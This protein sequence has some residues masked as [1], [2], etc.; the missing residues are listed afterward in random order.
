MCGHV[1]A[2]LSTETFILIIA[3]AFMASNAA[4]ELT[5]YED[6]SVTITGS[7][8]TVTWGQDYSFDVSNLYF[9]NSVLGIGDDRNISV[10][11]DTVTGTSSIL[12]EYDLS[13]PLVGDT[14]LKIETEAVTGST[15]GY[16][17]TGIPSITDGQYRLYMDGE[18]KDVYSSGGLITW[19]Q[20]SWNSDH[21]FTLFYVSEEPVV[22]DLSP[23]GRNVEPG[24]TEL[25]VDVEDDSGLVDIG[26]YREDNSVIESLNSVEPGDHSIMWETGSE[27]EFNWYVNVSDGLNTVTSRKAAFTTIDLELGW[28][29]TSESENGFRIYSNTTGGYSRIGTVGENVESFTDTA[30]DLEFGKHICYRVTSYNRFGESQPLEGCVTP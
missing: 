24:S 25:A 6:D 18:P 17:F 27:R 28:N 21:R 5:V 26:F 30:S 20:S 8:S 15:V 2:K 16:Q 3:F 7:N 9:A 23:E 29:D 11:S 1:F 4:A 19:S 22:Q 13:T 14:V 10:V 12:E